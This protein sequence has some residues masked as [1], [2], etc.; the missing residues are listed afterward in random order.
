MSGSDHVLNVAAQGLSSDGR[1]ALLCVAWAWLGSSNSL[2]CCVL[3]WAPV[4]CCRA[5]PGPVPVAGGLGPAKNALKVGHK[6]QRAGPGVKRILVVLTGPGW[7]EYFSRTSLSSLTGVCH[8][9]PLSRHLP[10]AGHPTQPVILLLTLSLF[11]LRS[12]CY[13]LRLYKLLPGPHQSGW[14][15]FLSNDSV[16]PTPGLW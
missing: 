5:R 3:Q 1:G 13:L 4:L 10:G 11:S 8:A 12:S 14:R 6:K 15:F 7:S 16:T 9:V 2:Q